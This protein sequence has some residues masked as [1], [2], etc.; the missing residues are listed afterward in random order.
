MASSEP[1]GRPRAPFQW[2]GGKG[3]F[4]RHILPLLP[5][6]HLYCEP[7]AGSGMLLF[8][9]SAAPIEVL[10]DLNGDIVNLFRC[11]QEPERLARLRRRLR[12]TLYHQGEFRRALEVLA[13]SADPDLRAWAF[14]VGAR[15]G[16]GGIFRGP[17]SWG[18]DRLNSHRGMA[19]VVSRWQTAQ[20]LLPAWHER[21]RRVVLTQEDGVKTL[22]RFDCADAV[23]YVDPP[24]PLVA[25]RGKGYAHEM[26]DDQHRELV[27]A[28]CDLRGAA[29]VSSYDNPIYRPLERAGYQR[30]EIR[31]ACYAASRGRGSGLVG[32]GAALA[33]VPRAE[34][35]YWRHT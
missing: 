34:V 35:L 32:K 2:Y 14:F 28:L 16:F 12:Y 23:F 17:G 15:Q 31:T 19:G 30:K 11:L 13:Q 3:N 1:A 7:Y 33:K 25:R 29:V 9:R 26:T 6:R 22:R 20:D 5:M 10:N 21:L 4:F 18:Y 24:Y 8:A 27:A